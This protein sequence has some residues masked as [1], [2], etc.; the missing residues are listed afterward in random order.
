MK[1]SGEISDRAVLKELGGRIARHRLNK[2][3]TQAILATEAGVSTP[4]IQRIEQGK[5]SQSA[6]LIRILRTLK[7]LENLEILIPEPA[8]SPIQQAK[9]HG[10]RR[11]RASSPSGKMD[12]P[13]E[14]IWGEDE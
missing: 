6:N 12:Q 11:Q 5:S 4:T 3:L 7:L 8:V 10:K 2:N 13:S 1:V 9:M 14:W